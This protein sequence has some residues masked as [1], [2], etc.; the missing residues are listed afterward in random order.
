MEDTKVSPDSIF[1]AEDC[2]AQRKL[3][4]LAMQ[5]AQPSFK[6]KYFS[7]GELLLNG[8]RELDRSKKAL[9]AIILLDIEM[10]ILD[11]ID[12]LKLL[13]EH[14]LFDQIQIFMFSTIIDQEVGDNLMEL[15]A[16]GS[17]KKPINFDELVDIILYFDS[18]LAD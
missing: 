17:I 2:P 7:N 18:Y 4:S 15:G 10:P 3:F 11:G 8:L 5:E 1:Y 9:P 13:R 14:I 12:T 16:N 6:V